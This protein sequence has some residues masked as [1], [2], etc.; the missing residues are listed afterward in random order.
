LLLGI[1]SGNTCVHSMRWPK[2]GAEIWLKRC[3]SAHAGGSTQL[4][5]SVSSYSRHLWRYRTH[6]RSD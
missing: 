4:V 6:G 1:I 2:L 3:Y 5:Q